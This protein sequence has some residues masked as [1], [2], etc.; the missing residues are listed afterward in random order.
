MFRVTLRPYQKTGFGWLRSLSETG[1][2]GILADD[3]G[4]G[5]TV[6]TLALLA[7]R[8]LGPTTP[9]RPSLL[10]VPTSLV[11]AWR[12]QANE[13]APDLKILVLHGPDRQKN[14][15]AI[16]SHHAVITSYPLLNRD[17][18]VLTAIDWEIVVL[19]E[20]QTVK[21]PASAIAKRIRELKS[22]MRLALTGTPMEN[23][24]L[25]L[26]SIFD[27]LIPGLLGDRKTFRSRFLVPIE[28]HGDARA[29]SELNARIRP[30]L[31]RRTKE[32]VALDL[33]EKT[34]ITELIELEGRQAAL[35]ESIRLTMDERV[36]KAIAERG[37]AA[38]QITILDAL[39]KLRQICCDPLLLK[40][41]AAKTATES[42]KRT[43]LMELLTTLIAEGRR[44]LVFSQFV[45]M[46]RLIEADVKAQ[47]W[48]Y[49]WLTGDTIDRDTVVS[50]FQSGDAPI[51]LIS[52]KAGGGRVDAD[53]GGHGHPLR[54]V[55]EPGRRAPGHG[56]RS[57]HRAG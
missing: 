35:Y 56:P 48:N 52:L 24:L 22:A 21:N 28:T 10:V 43:R 2:G 50:G 39:L 12:R 4:L 40:H 15:D 45:E 29:Q 20:A 32:Q 14:F 23:S 51:F 49:A 54:S 5:K 19:D 38:S 47:G 3:M 36:R 26:W 13:F 9:A 11:R 55:V 41:D 25:D 57:P 8:H 44:V 18:A 33:P 31:M 53:G 27:W 46:L 7:E 6:Q 30:F 42:T 34:Q 1:F 37:V 16:A 17:H